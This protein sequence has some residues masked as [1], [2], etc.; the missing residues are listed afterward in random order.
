MAGS[1]AAEAVLVEVG[2]VEHEE[3]GDVGVAVLAS[4]EI[5]QGDA[6]FLADGLVGKPVAV[7]VHKDAVGETRLVVGGTAVQWAPVVGLAGDGVDQVL[8]EHGGELDS[9]A[10]FACNNQRVA[11]DGRRQDGLAA[12]NLVE[13]R[14]EVSVAV[15]AARS[16]HHC[17]PCPNSEVGAVLLCHNAHH[18]SVL[19]H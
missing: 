9:G 19:H 3:A 10:D 14:G 2:L 1:D 8:L 16:Q 4:V 15:V 11:L 5:A 6:N 7:E 13:P 12:V 17:V 18:S